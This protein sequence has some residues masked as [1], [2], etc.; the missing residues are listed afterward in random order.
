MTS[1]GED[2]YLDWGPFR[3]CLGACWFAKIKP[4]ST[5]LVILGYCIQS[6]NSSCWYKSTTLT[7]L[8]ANHLRRGWM[9]MVVQIH[10]FWRFHT[11]FVPAIWVRAFWSC[12]ILWYFISL[13]HHKPSKEGN[14]WEFLAV[15]ECYTASETNLGLLPDFRE[16]RSRLL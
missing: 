8:Q 15:S 5:S 6:I 14:S 3:L 2:L 1:S 11:K 13:I 12:S 4:I 10:L 7:A 9:V 16:M